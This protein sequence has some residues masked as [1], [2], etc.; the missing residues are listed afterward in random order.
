VAVDV[1]L[2]ADPDYTL[3]NLLV[4]MQSAGMNP[5]EVMHELA[6]SCRLVGRRIQRRRDPRAPEQRRTG[7]K[8]KDPR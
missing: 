2:A 7:K 1:A 8:R 5:Y 3:A 4:D 6:S